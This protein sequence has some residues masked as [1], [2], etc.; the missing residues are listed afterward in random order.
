MNTDTHTHTP[1][2]EYIRRATFQPSLCLHG[3]V[4]VVHERVCVRVCDGARLYAFP[5]EPLFRATSHTLH[6]YKRYTLICRSLIAIVHSTA[7]HTLHTRTERLEKVTSVLCKITFKYRHTHAYTLAH[8]RKHT[9]TDD[10]WRTNQHCALGVVAT[11]KAVERWKFIAVFNLCAAL[12][13][14]SRTCSSQQKQQQRE[15]KISIRFKN[16]EKKIRQK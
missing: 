10:F 14:I 13:E 4:C 1:V 6:K 11:S 9:S 7:Q 8:A 15:K 2:D 16:S 3:S 5:I 12:E